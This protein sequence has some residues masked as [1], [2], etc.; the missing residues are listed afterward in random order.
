MSTTSTF[1]VD[2]GSIG[3]GYHHTKPT[4]DSY[5][6]W[7]LPEWALN[8]YLNLPNNAVCRVPADELRA[9]AR[10]IIALRKLLK[11]VMREEAD[12]PKEET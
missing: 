1:N 9:C 12:W 5:D 10:D 4:P 7:L 6:G 2:G 8:A 3:R 11:A